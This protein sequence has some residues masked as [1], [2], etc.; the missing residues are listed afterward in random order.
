MDTHSTD[1]GGKE[2]GGSDLW[3][4][5]A[6]VGSWVC[7]STLALRVSSEEAAAHAKALGLEEM[8]PL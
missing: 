1:L 6:E 8:E 2:A 7:P 5:G 4:S 3:P